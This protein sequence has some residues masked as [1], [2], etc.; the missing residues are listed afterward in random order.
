MRTPLTTVL[1]NLIFLLLTPCQ[2][3]FFTAAAAAATAGKW[4]LLNSS[5]G[6]SAMHMQLLHNDRVIIFDRNSFG[7][8][9][10]SLPDG[11]CIPVP[12]SGK[13]DCSAHSVE[14]DVANNSIRPLLVRTDF[15]CSSG[16]VTPD[17][18]LVQ[19]GGFDSG[20]H[21]VR[22]FPP[23]DDGK[24]DWKEIQGGLLQ[25][26][27][28]A[29]NHILP[30]GRTIIVGGRSAF[31]YEFYPSGAGTR[32]LY[33]LPF[34]KETYYKNRAENNLYPF[35]FLNVDGNLFI[36]ANNRAILF[37]YRNIT[38]VRTYPE[39]PTGDPRCY[40]STGSAVLLPLMNLEDPATVSAEVM[41]CGGA[42]AVAFESAKNG[43]FLRAL[44]TCG[45]IVIT[46]PNPQWVMETMPSPRLMGDMV[47]LPNG[48]VLI[49]NGASSG[50]AGWEYA[51]DPVLNP[52]LY[53]PDGKI[54]AR[55][56][57]QAPSKR[58]RMYHSS[59]ILLRDGRVLVG[60]GNPYKAYN[61]TTN[62]FPTD[63]SLESFSPPY[64]DPAFAQLRPQIISPVRN[65]KFG[66]G[67]RVS[68]LFTVPGPIQRD[69]VRITLLA[70]P[71]AT[72]S[73]SMNQRLLGLG[74][75]TVD[76]VGPDQNIYQMDVNMPG[77]GNL[78][79][80][81]YYL[82]FVVHQ[83]IPSVGVWVQIQ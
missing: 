25:R 82:L 15:W 53:R 39:I 33:A 67:S 56:E 65:S 49:L 3:N 72:H 63:L 75:L 74:S 5:I 14:Y 13:L 32:Q 77:S 68:V 48:N 44:D 61:F 36:F 12:D 81:G 64:L 41:V 46:D 73:F 70:P 54:G 2:H 47:M 7:D 80:A 59:A 52:V 76:S 8:S 78:A 6:I 66:Y 50:S 40:P 30:D 23:C 42:K 31:S 38:V 79:P 57:L 62:L 35:V 1:F 29:T 27:W 11:Q 60:G 58:P 83:E 20:D 71:F 18:N 34:L 69:K 28:Y 4:D 21:V 22:I 51:R 16:S 10:I 37:N 19:T 17:G 45:R 9:N 26:R 24:C 55:F 43:S